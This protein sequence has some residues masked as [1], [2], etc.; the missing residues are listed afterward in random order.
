MMILRLLL[1]ALVVLVAI[2]QE[3]PPAVHFTLR[4]RGGP[5]AVQKSAN[6]TYLTEQLALAEARFNLTRRE[7]RGNKIVRVPKERLVG[8]ADP[9]RLLGEVGQLGNW[10]VQEHIHVEAEAHWARFAT[11]KL[12]EP[13]QNIEMDL[14][15]LTADF[16]VTTTT[17]S[18][19]SRFEDLFSTTYG[20]S[21][22]M[23]FVQQG[24]TRHKR[25]P[26][27]NHFQIAGCQPIRSSF[28]PATIRSLFNF[29]IA[30]HQDRVDR[31]SSLRAAY[32]DSLH[33]TAFARW[34]YLL[35][36]SSCSIRITSNQKSSPSR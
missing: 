1:S 27:Q 14:D 11:L 22:F 20:R 15:L 2:A 12:G 21:I 19:G 26:M 35:S 4:R 5:F 10:Y 33:Q 31:R 7:V 18:S 17:S 28:P 9:E 3:S 30:S 29:H 23:P 36:S 25:G 8:G 24:L 34:M 13:A 32:S 16:S 6:M